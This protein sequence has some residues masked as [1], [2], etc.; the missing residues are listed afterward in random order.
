MVFPVYAIMWWVKRSKLLDERWRLSK[1]SAA[2]AKLDKLA[3]SWCEKTTFVGTLDVKMGNAVSVHWAERA[4]RCKDSWCLYLLTAKNPLIFQSVSI[5]YIYIL[6][7][8]PIYLFI[9]QSINQ[10]LHNFTCRIVCRLITFISAC[11]KL[12]EG[13]NGLLPTGEAHQNRELKSVWTRQ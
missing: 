5:I 9:Y 4:K 10:S 3:R 2:L 13:W 12:N 6:L 8:P 1:L 11:E 7:S